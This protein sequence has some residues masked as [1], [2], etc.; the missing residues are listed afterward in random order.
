MNALHPISRMYVGVV[1]LAAIIFL[2]GHGPWQQSG[3]GLVLEVVR[4][5]IEFVP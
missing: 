3:G 4:S 2:P 5:Q 1:R